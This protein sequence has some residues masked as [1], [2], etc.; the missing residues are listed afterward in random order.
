MTRIA[1]VALLTFVVFSLSA[2]VVW[3]ASAPQEQKYTESFDQEEAWNNQYLA[4]AICFGLGIAVF[5]GYDTHADQDT[6]HPWH[7]LPGRR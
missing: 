7:R 2:P 6:D 5:G 4:I 3:A 1:R